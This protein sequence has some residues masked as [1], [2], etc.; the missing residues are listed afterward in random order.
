[1][2]LYGFSSNTHIFI[3]FRFK[4]STFNNNVVNL[5]TSILYQRMV[6]ANWIF[7]PFESKFAPV[8]LSVSAIIQSK[9]K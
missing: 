2:K 5:T 7:K 8:Y 6:S 4:P 9:N 3:D 1:M